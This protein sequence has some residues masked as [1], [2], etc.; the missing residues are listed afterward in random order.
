MEEERHMKLKQ[1][2][3]LVVVITLVA[4]IS[5]PAANATAQE[6]SSE[7]LFTNPGFEQGYYN[8]D[9]I[10]QIAVPN[11]W[12]MWWLD[13]V[14]FAGTEDRPAYRPETVVWNI[15]D[16]PPNERSL[17]FRDGSYTLKVFKS[18]APM[19][20]ALS[21]DVQGLQVGRKYRIVA[22]IFVDIVEDYQGGKKV[23]PSRANAGFVRF[24]VGPVGAPWLDATQ[25]N[26]SPYWNGEN[27]QPFY[28]AQPI[29]VWDFTATAEN[30][31]VWI[32]MGSNYPYRNNGFFMDGVGL[33]ALNE[34]GSVPPS[35]GSGNS[36]GGGAPAQPAAT[37]TPFPTPTP[38]ADGSIIHK[39]QT[40]ET[41]WTI[42]IQYAPAL[43]VTPEQALP[44]IQERNNNPAFI[45]VGQELVIA[46]PGTTNT[47]AEEASEETAAEN[48][49]S[50]EETAET[51][52]TPEPETDAA[53]EETAA[54]SEAATE[55]ITEVAAADTSTENSAAAE[56]EPSTSNS[57]C[58]TVFNDANANAARE[59][60]SEQLQADA[61]VTLF[62]A[63]N[64]VSTYVSDG[65]SE[66]YC[67]EDLETDT[68]QVQVFPPADYVMTTAGT[69]AVALSGGD[70]IAVSFGVQPQPAAP[71]A[72]VAAADT[73]STGGDTAVADT[74]SAETVNAAATDSG[75]FFSSVG[76][77]VLAI[78]AVLVLLAGAGVVMLRRA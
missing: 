22:P 75:G 39:V 37:V 60:D 26:Y 45:N 9:N 53:A 55:D 43:G 8:Q 52:A 69:W 32:E 49:E 57:I 13:G 70:S 58:V 35:S 2:A 28:Q 77:I 59:S 21:Q 66:P 73:S 38:R 31:T 51:D 67:F 5:R 29:F 74:G 47:T 64:S 11:G 72:E 19:Y 20:A 16:A 7:N 25:I 71:A 17:F 4:L 62:R 50:A 42:A 24:G 1:L 33:Y 61:A 12:R 41:M 27:V 48:E 54:D 10:S 40:G 18:W 6:Q 36:G 34:T 56:T 63:G 68:Y 14:P 30:M 15:Q 23:P 76:G 3:L 46:P 78:A 65:I 44:L